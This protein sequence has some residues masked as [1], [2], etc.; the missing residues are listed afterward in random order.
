MGRQT[1]ASLDTTSRN[2]GETWRTTWRRG[3]GRSWR[4]QAYSELERGDSHARLVLPAECGVVDLDCDDAHAGRAGK[5][6]ADKSGAVVNVQAVR[7][8]GC[9]VEQVAWR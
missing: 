7:Q 5:R 3:G 4:C 8:V 2:T 1:A 6:T 9:Q